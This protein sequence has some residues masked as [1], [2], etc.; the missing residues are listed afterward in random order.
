MLLSLCVIICPKTTFAQYSQYYECKRDNGN[1]YWDSTPCIYIKHSFEVKQMIETYSEL[2]REVNKL[3]GTSNI[4]SLKNVKRLWKEQSPYSPLGNYLIEKY[5]KFKIGSNKQRRSFNASTIIKLLRINPNDLS[6][7]SFGNKLWIK[8]IEELFNYLPAWGRGTPDVDPY[9]FIYFLLNSP[10]KYVNQERLYQ[11]VYDEAMREKRYNIHDLDEY[12]L[13]INP[14]DE[15]INNVMYKCSVD[16]YCN[17][18]QKEKLLEY[19]VE[20]GHYKKNRL[21]NIHKASVSGHYDSSVFPK[22]RKLYK[23]SV[24]S[25]KRVLR[26]QRDNK[27][28]D[29]MVDEF[30]NNSSKEIPH[31]LDA[32]LNEV[33]NDDPVS[34]YLVN[35]YKD[36]RTLASKFA[37]AKLLLNKP[38]FIKTIRFDDDDWVEYVGELFSYLE[39]N[40]RNKSRA[41]IG[42]FQKFLLSMP[43]EKINQR[44]LYDD[45][46]HMA[47]QEDVRLI[48]NDA[49]RLFSINPI[50]ERVVDVVYKCIQEF[51][52]GGMGKA[53]KLVAYFLDEE[54]FQRGISNKLFSTI[55]SGRERLPHSF[56]QVW[57]DERNKSFFNKS[58]A[59][60][61]VEIIRHGT[62]IH[63]V[64]HASHLLLISVINRDY[65]RL[66]GSLIPLIRRAQNLDGEEHEVSTIQKN[67][68][69]A[70]LHLG[71]LND[72]KALYNIFSEINSEKLRNNFAYT[73]IEHYSRLDQYEQLLLDSKSITHGDML[74]HQ[75]LLN[76]CCGTKPLS[77]EAVSIL[78]E[79]QTD[80]YP[81]KIRSKAGENYIRLGYQLNQLERLS[82][83]ETDDVRVEK[84]D[85]AYFMILS[86]T[87]FVVIYI[88]KLRQPNGDLKGV[89]L[90]YFMLNTLYLIP[91]I[92]FA[93]IASIGHNSPNTSGY[94]SAIQFGIIIYVILE[95]L[96]IGYVVIVTEK[97]KLDITS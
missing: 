5:Y 29:K 2:D 64:E 46:Y 61:Y 79:Y 84:Y 31:E 62:E 25:I 82:I 86:I 58:S 95:L 52:C 15:R 53:K 87:L 93:N 30:I 37:I 20:Y 27:K 44:R 48:A 39:S 42:V 85:Y 12:L 50:D 21:K 88:S 8:F 1:T 63:Q 26:F 89:V 40:E 36:N 35:K 41:K 13:R 33:G 6:R 75:S 16:R 91:L 3:L 67:L 94:F 81:K 9:S 28:L 55:A 71:Q 70:E 45:I 57:L 80:T 54:R 43:K 18:V 19:F 49:K 66:D 97:R 73:I 17:K 7:V 72:R 47:M 68:I 34:E 10:K 74:L 76:S 90:K 38:L 96:F 92:V 32:L 69:Q 78:R 23:D 60:S 22:K 14:K 59:I 51:D 65:D 11:I 4:R 77:A 56:Y 83:L 24:V